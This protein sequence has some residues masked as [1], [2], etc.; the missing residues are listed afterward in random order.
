MTIEL[1][2]VVFDQTVLFKQ[3]RNDMKDDWFPDPL[4]FR[5]M[6]EG[7]ILATQIV[8]NFE[9]NHGEYV[10]IK[11]SIYNLPKA[12]FTLRYALKTGLCDRTLYHGLT[13]FLVPYFDKLIPWNVFSHRYDYL[14]RDSKYMFKRAIPAYRH[15]CPEIT[16]R[17]L[18]RLSP[19]EMNKKRITLNPLARDDK[20]QNQ[21][22]VASGQLSVMNSLS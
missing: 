7:G 9:G 19:Y 6:I 12:N 1:G 15:W 20:N 5:D 17:S 11:R 18:R 13:S 16:Q 8:S 10:P 4:N 3:L 21:L 14:R 22:S 2:P